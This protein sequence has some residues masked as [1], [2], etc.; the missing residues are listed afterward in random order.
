MKDLKEV[1]SKIIHEREILD[2]NY[3]ELKKMP[4]NEF[5]LKFGLD[6]IPQNKIHE[7]VL[8][9]VRKIRQAYDIDEEYNTF[10]YLASAMRVYG[11]LS[12]EKTLQQLNNLSTKQKM[13][14]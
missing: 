7:T 12:E 2:K 5:E 11:L 8:E 10:E 9:T 3:Q 13:K 14:E 1:V 4:V 6:F